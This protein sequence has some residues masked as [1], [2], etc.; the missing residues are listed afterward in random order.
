MERK[1]II[2]GKDYFRNIKFKSIGG[3]DSKQI[4]KD[5]RIQAERLRQGY[6][7]ALSQANQYRSSLDIPDENKS[8]G[9]YIDVDI[10][11]KH[12]DVKA[13]DSK[14]GAQLVNLKSIDTHPD[15]LK[16]TLFLADKHKD[17]L[18]KKLDNYSD[19][20]KDC[21]NQD[22]SKGLPAS[23]ALIN[24]LEAID[25]TSITDFF[26][27]E[28]DRDKFI[29]Y[30]TKAC[31][32]YELWVRK[33]ENCPFN[34]NELFDRLDLLGIEHS[35]HC[36]EF[37]ETI[38]VLIKT[39]KENLSHLIYVLDNLSELRILKQ[40]SILINNISQEKEWGDLILNEFEKV[41]RP[42]RIGI[43]DSG[44]NNHHPLLKS[45]LPDKRCH[46]A[47]STVSIRDMAQHGSLMAGLTL[48]GDLTETIYQPGNVLVYSDL[49]SVKIMPGK[50]E[51]PNIP[52][53]YGVIAEDAIQT[54]L[55]DESKIQC[56]AITAEGNTNGVP[57]SW[58]SA[59]DE[60]LFNNGQSDVLLFVS[61]GNVLETGDCPYP[62]FNV[63]EE[64]KDPA[65]SWN[66]ITVG[67]YT[68]KVAIS[69]PNYNGIKPIAPKGGLSPYSSTSLSWEN[70]LVK[71]EI[72]MEGGNAIDDHENLSS[73]P[74]DL[75]LIS[76]SSQPAIHR[77][78]TIC[79][80]SA[81]T[82]LAA[83]LA[84]KIK[85]NNPELSPLSIRALMIHSAEW[86]EEMKHQNTK[87]REL[88]INA[89]LH[90]CGYGVPVEK[91]AIMSED[92]YATF[93]AEQEMTPLVENT[94]KGY[95]MD[96]M[97]LYDLPWP[98][99]ILENMGEEKV[100]LKITLSY[101]IQPSP[102]SK[103]RLSKY[104]YPSLGLRFEVNLPTE[105]ENVFVKRVSH[106][107]MEDV[108]KSKNDYKRWAI[109]ISR[110]NNGCIMSDYITDTAANI[111][112]CNKIAI[113][114]VTGWWNHRKYTEDKSIKY[115][116]IVSIKTKETK[117]YNT[118]KLPIAIVN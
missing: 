31:I 80:T 48:F 110:R 118:I 96:S 101:Y 9:S 69:D 76:T 8:K 7:N 28:D 90:T 102:G 43:L 6:K 56:T 63:N 77:F 27:Q 39:N 89:I 45:F 55:K 82:A 68:E 20:E 14:T 52:E 49:S 2:I 62:D 74:A 86:T 106:V 71:P 46:N 50:E 100:T 70:N 42:V 24:N 18:T 112:S 4:E 64:V 47:T 16:A 40:P 11:S 35:Q 15:L 109:G 61:A 33:E 78:D 21:S 111:A 67:A 23:A 54:N 25:V 94:T 114:P 37:T 38:V 85:Y 87:N 17:W 60:T 36:I 12:I 29:L 26:T 92:C 41:N 1:H 32:N 13:L 88:D 72:L 99:E 116:L 51:I 83:R 97:H 44:V 81:S 73:A 66:A 113:Y 117:I 10:N 30:K 65:Q 91:R 3:R 57:S 79:A 103:S 93:I 75:N 5:R 34:Q 22:G 84:A 105:R 95:K 58:S 108:E 107:K 19:S 104:K 98:K 115:S 53:L 59:I